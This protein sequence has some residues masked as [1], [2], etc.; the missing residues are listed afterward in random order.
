[1]Q[2]NFEKVINFNYQFGIINSPKP[3]IQPAILQSPQAEFCLNL[4]REEVS[5]LEQA[6]KQNDLIETIDALADILYVVYGMGARIGVNLDSAFKLVHENNMSKLCT[7]EEEAIASVAYYIANPQFGYRSPAYKR[8]HDNVHYVV[9]N[10]DTNKV[11]KSVNYKSVD[12]S[13]LI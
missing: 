12:L 2:T 11:L 3:I 6:V 1:M 8:A 9:Y 10:R 4:I 13:S 5:E 7:T